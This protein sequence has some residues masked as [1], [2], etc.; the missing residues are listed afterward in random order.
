MTLETWSHWLIIAGGAVLVIGWVGAAFVK[1]PQY[2]RW[3]FWL[4]SLLGIT[5]ISLSLADRGWSTVAI[6]GRVLRCRWCRNGMELS[7]PSC[8]WAY[9]RRGL[10]RRH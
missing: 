6:F 9:L 4:G 10:R 2:E 1:D 3:M 8:C 5:F 7:H